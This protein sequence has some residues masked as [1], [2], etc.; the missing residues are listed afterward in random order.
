MWGATGLSLVTESISSILGITSMW[1]LD[2]ELIF[3]QDLGVLNQALE[4]LCSSSAK[5]GLQLNLAKCALIIPTPVA[6]GLKISPHQDS[7]LLAQFTHHHDTIILG[8][9]IECDS[10]EATHF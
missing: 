1:C 4:L 3:G 6:E 8:T 9:P 10:S 2:V 5:I 7:S